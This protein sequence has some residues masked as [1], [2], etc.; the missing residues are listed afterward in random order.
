MNTSSIFNQDYQFNNP[1]FVAD[2]YMVVPASSNPGMYIELFN[3][4]KD[5][6]KILDDWGKVGPIFG[7]LC[8]AHSTYATDIKLG[9]DDMDEKRLLYVGDCVYYNG[10]YY[11][12]VNVFF[13]KSYPSAYGE[14][15]QEFKEELAIPPTW[16]V[17]QSNENGVNNE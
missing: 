7:P 9:F 15:F 1:I 2:P 11:G 3:G 10:V 13:V 16:E 14:R 8:F 4:R 6:D 5:P 17:K 12:E